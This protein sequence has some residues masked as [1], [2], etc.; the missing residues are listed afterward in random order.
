MTKETSVSGP[1]YFE[2]FDM[3]ATYRHARGKTI[4]ESDAVTICN[5]VLNT[6][7]GHFNDH[8]M[9]SLPVGESVVFGGVTISMIIGLASQDTA[10]NAIRELGMTNIKLLSPVKH[11]DTLYAYST[12]L[13][14]ELRKEGG[15]ITFTHYGVNQNET[16]VFQGDRTVILKTRG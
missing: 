6:A 8:K 7:E 4:K 11:G 1:Y 12:V 13:E 15:L 14:K 10:G 3:G 2:D 9:E 16:L 5:L